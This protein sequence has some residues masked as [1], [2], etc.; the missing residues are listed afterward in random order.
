M[1]MADRT[2]L[3][4]TRVAV[5][6]W[7]AVASTSCWIARSIRIGFRFGWIGFASWFLAILFAATMFSFDL[8]QPFVPSAGRISAI[9]THAARTSSSCASSANLLAC[10]LT[11]TSNPTALPVSTPAFLAARGSSFGPASS[12]ACQPKPSWLI[13]SRVVS[14]YFGETHQ[15][16]LHLLPSTARD[17]NIPHRRKAWPCLVAAKVCGVPFGSLS[18][19]PIMEMV[20][21]ET[22]DTCD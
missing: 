6:L 17:A 3:V 2:V 9:S 12:P 15:A 16:W 7:K 10:C 21:V 20:P 11:A 22:E 19:R 18:T 14:Q 1:K 8:V 5:P 13:S 4:S